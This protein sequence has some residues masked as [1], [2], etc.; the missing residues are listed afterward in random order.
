MKQFLNDDFL[1]KNATAIKLYHEVASKTP[2]L[3][4]HCHIS[5][6]EIA[7]DKKFKN[8]TELWLGG[9][10]YK[11][12]LMRSNGISEKYITGDASD[13]E[14]FLMWSKTIAKAIGNPLYHWSH[15][16]LKRYFDYDGIL[17]EKTAPLVWELCN[18]KLAEPS[19]S[20]LNLI[21]RSNVKLICTTDDP[22]DDLKWHEM[23]K[24]DESFKVKVLP[25]FR[26]DK[27]LNIDK[28][29]FSSYLNDLEKVTNLKI[30]S[31]KDL[32]KAISLRI[33]HFASHGC[34]AADHGLDYMFCE[35][36]NEAELDAILLN[37]KNTKPN[38]KDALKYK[39][40]L[41]FYLA[42]EYHKR[43]WVMQLHFGAKRNNN[44]Q[45]FKK[46]GPDTG[47]DAIANKASTDDLA[48]FLDLLN[49]HDRLPKTIC[50]SLNPNDDDI[51]ASI[52]GSFQSD[53][54]MAK[55]QHGSAW[56]FND[57]IAGM[58]KQMISLANQSC[59]ANFIGM[60]TDSRSFLSYTRHEYF[61]RILCNLIGEWIEEGEY[62]NDP[63]FVNEIIRN[64]SYNNAITYFNFPLDKH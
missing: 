16:E 63:E 35:E 15:L 54:A 29:G 37:A 26:P 14:K 12:R 10:H 3:D 20:A 19:F 40:A 5:P 1:L 51:I 61:R 58:R 48:N 7:I 17:N 11:W 6:M 52:I 62:P 59:L 39:T 43:S 41:L 44:T 55:I 56:W 64:I 21:I 50:Y 22:I 49:T 4:Y 34:L 32:K 60:L 42:G 2:I 53:E 38:L 28:D 46:L 18:K 57:H 8:I 13:Y 30:E 31:F 27:L 33:E 24:D 36:Y 45:N 9:D 25:A 23:I 47:F